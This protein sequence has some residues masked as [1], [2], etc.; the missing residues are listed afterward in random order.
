M[1]TQFTVKHFINVKKENCNFFSII[2][3]LLILFILN[4]EKFL[5]K[6]NTKKLKLKLL[7]KYLTVQ[8][9]LKM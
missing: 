4:Y 9:L 8:I 7:L 6:N 5:K 1:Y 2:L 3:C